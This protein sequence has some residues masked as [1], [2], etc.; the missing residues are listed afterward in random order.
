MAVVDSASDGVASEPDQLQAATV[1]LLPRRV[2]VARHLINR[3]I[4]MRFGCTINAAGWVYEA[5]HETAVHRP[6]AS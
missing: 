6:G 1:A 2:D 3:M 4:A 5:R